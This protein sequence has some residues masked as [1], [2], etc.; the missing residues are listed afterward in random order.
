MTALQYFKTGLLSVTV[1]S[2][3]G[4]STAFN[5]D[6]GLVG[7]DPLPA[8][9]GTDGGTEL[10]GTPSLMQG[11]DRQGW[12]TVKVLVPREQIA[13]PPTYAANFRWQHDRV[14]WDPSYPTA[15]A[16]LDDPNDPYQDVADALTEP[17]VTAAMLAWAPIDMIFI[18]QPWEQQHSPSERYALVPGNVPAHLVD[19]FSAPQHPHP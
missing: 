12:S 11:L 19:W 8:L 5:D 3:A 16:A 10:T 6:N 1:V 4:C 14:P 9:A 7:I 15:V 2:V 18:T 17:W 13:H